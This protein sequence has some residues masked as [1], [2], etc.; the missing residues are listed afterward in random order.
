[1]GDKI[2]VGP[3]PG[4]LQTNVTPFNVDDKS[5]PTLINAYQWRGRIKRK[6]GTAPLCRLIRFFNSSNTAYGS[7][8]SIT[9]D[10]SGNGNLLTGFSL[11]TNGTIV[12]GTVTL[13]GSVGVVTY[14]DPTMDGYLTPTGTGGANTINYSTGAILIPAQAGGT[15]TAIFNYNPALPVMGI[16]DYVTGNIQFPGTI[17]FDTKYSYNGV[18]AFPY[19][20][21][22]VSFYKNPAVSS[23]LP[24]YV[25]KAIETPTTWN[26]QDYQQ[27]W[28]T[29]YQGALWATNGITNPFSITN[30][31]MQYKPIN[32]APASVHPLSTTTANLNIIGHGL[33][34]GD[35]VFINEVSTTTGINY[36]TGYVTTVVDA[37]NVIVTFPNATLTGD[38]TGGIAQYLT[39]RSDVTKDCL[40]F[41]DGDPT[42]GNITNPSLTG[43]NGWV[44]FAPVLNQFPFSIADSPA[45]IW[46]L[47]G[48]RMIVPFK[49]RL[50]F[51]G[52]V[53]QNSSPGS[54][55]YL[56]DTTIYSQNGT[57]YYTVSYTNKPVATADTPTIP[58]T[59]NSIL[60]PLNQTAT[61]T[62]YFEDQTGFGGFA[63]A[64]IDQP[65]N[66][67]APNEDVLIMGFNTNQ[68]R[69]VYTGNDIV[70]FNYFIINSELGSSSTFSAVT[71]DRGVIT[72]GSRGYIITSQQSADRID[73]L[74]PDQVFEIQ[75]INNGT[76]RICSQR[77]YINEW[78][79]FTY[80]S[81]EVSYKFPNQT[82]FYNYRDNTWAIFNESYTTYGSFRKQ[83]GFTW[84][85][86]GSVYASWSVWNDPWNAG[87]STLLQPQVAAGNAQGFIVTKGDGTGEANSLYIQSISGSLVTSPN[88]TL[89]NG[90][91][92]IINGA[93]GPVGTLVNGQIFSVENPD[94]NTF[95][96]N[97]PIASS[98]YLGNGLITRMYVPFIQTKQFPTAWG[99]GRKTRLGPQQYLFTTTFESQV[100]VN[101]Y[102][103]QNGS[104]PYNS[105]LLVPNESPNNSLIYSKTVYTCPES[106]NLG[107]TPANVNLQMPTAIDQEQTWHRLNTSLIGDTVQVGITLTNDQMRDVEPIGVIY[108][109]TGA[110]NAI[111]VKLST[112]AQFETGQLVFITGV[113]GMTQ[114]NGNIYQ[115]VTS[116]ATSVTINVN[117]TLFGTYVSGGTIQLEAGINGFAEIELH[118]IILDVSPSQVLA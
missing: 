43:V 10:V 90:D 34:I 5:F 98:T 94:T 100:T 104:Q 46:Y 7:I 73:L 68:A 12:P 26:G 63:S 97:P 47:V 13:V 91:Y 85:T 107:L 110:T 23:S 17:Y 40:R 33:V 18:T 49:D 111:Q 20:S 36:Q 50:L 75:L 101:I 116:D 51:I 57:P 65:I 81:N 102:L 30:I 14:T 106:T 86:V 83:T 25:P 60:V 16:E 112:V 79:Y 66:T 78:I 72:R 15:I 109:I 113:M 84:Q 108:P 31:G 55:I 24:G 87:V 21:Y 8:G 59:Y 29:N 93:L 54:Q 67:V 117:G 99:M 27:F 38:G 74:I 118:G 4:G 41:Y 48:A 42:N 9:L 61:P 62:A 37:N 44:N 114:L 2:I 32:T 6:R 80:P 88:H 22:D 35:F 45:A 96:L 82:L 103:S 58:A 77:D 19:P 39:N 92:I 28:T 105:N 115:V 95:T 89:N 3:I 56:Q 1:M 70:P 76:E 11:Q 71:M 52:P 64:G 53:I 69:F